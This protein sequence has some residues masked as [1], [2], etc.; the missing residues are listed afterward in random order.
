MVP[1]RLIGAVIAVVLSSLLW[2]P[3][4]VAGA[5]VWGQREILTRPGVAGNAPRLFAAANDALTAAWVA[6]RT[7]A[8]DQPL[9]IRTKPDGGT[10]GPEQVVGAEVSG[11]DIELAVGDRL[12]AAYATVEGASPQVRTQATDDTFGASVLLAPELPGRV[13]S[14]PKLVVSR[15]GRQVV[16][17][18][19]RLPG[20]GNRIVAVRRDDSDA[21]WSKPKFL[22]SKDARPQSLAAGA[23]RDGSIAVL[24]TIVRWTDGARFTR[25]KHRLLSARGDWMTTE[26]VIES[27]GAGDLRVANRGYGRVTAMWVESDEQKHHAYTS[28]RTSSGRWTPARRIAVRPDRDEIWHTLTTNGRLTAVVWS[29]LPSSDGDSW[30]MARVQDGLNWSPPTRIA[31]ASSRMWLNAAA[32]APDGSLRLVWLRGQ[33]EL[34]TRVREAGGTWGPQT[35]ITWVGLDDYGPA[36]VAYGDRRAAVVSPTRSRRIDFAELSR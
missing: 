21:A 22:T 34:W 25:V 26:P 2:A 1:R 6:T 31:R 32:F 5:E 27:V 11:Y 8:G 24:W 30:L 7:S 35:R 15:S 28:S 36:V 3:E 13:L 12:V 9:V 17:W 20:L 33:G 29:S 19:Q 18:L 4:A 16:V 10:W 14:G 23:A